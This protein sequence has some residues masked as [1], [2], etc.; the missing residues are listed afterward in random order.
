[1]AKINRLWHYL[2][3]FATDSTGV[4][5]LFC[6]ADAVVVGMDPGATAVRCYPFTEQR[7]D[8][9]ARY[10]GMQVGELDAVVGKLDE[11]LDRL[12]LLTDEDRAEFI[13]LVG[14]PVASMIG[15]DLKALARRF[16]KESGRTVMGFST[17]GNRY[18]DEGMSEAL[19][20]IYDRHFRQYGDSEK[21][22]NPFLNENEKKETGQLKA[23]SLLGWNT[24]DF[25]EE[26]LRNKVMEHLEQHH[27]RICSIWG[28]KTTGEN[29]RHL[30][31]AD[32]NVVCSASG[33]RLAE[34]IKKNH[35]I[36]FVFLDELLEKTGGLEL[37]DGNLLIPEQCRRVLIIGEQITSNALRRRIREL[38]RLSGNTRREIVN[39]GFFLMN[40]KQMEEQ[41]IRLKSEDDLKRLL[42]EGAFDLVIGDP[43]FRLMADSTRRFISRKHPPVSGSFAD[44]FSD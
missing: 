10:K 30:P 27:M 25:P 18:Y 39:A 9:T 6:D 33:Y 1:M 21:T 26:T 7:Q 31:E 14:T 4:C 19:R 8:K 42:T 28:M 35:G 22:D 36:P 20:S 12:H 3:P 16:E 32:L 23:I 44:Q 2:M 43:M 17:T 41:D 24:L 15:V 38:D 29:W 34:K 37:L 40:S 5:S 11:S 13:V